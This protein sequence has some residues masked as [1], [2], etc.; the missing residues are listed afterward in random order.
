MSNN[1]ES[2]LPNAIRNVKLGFYIASVIIGF[3]GNTL[4]IAVISGKKNKRS[5]YDLFI[6]NLGIA[7][8]SFIV[9]Y[10]PLYIYE[11]LSSIYKTLLYC[12]LVQPLLTIFYFLSIFTIT[13]MAIHRCR[14]ITNPYKRKM[15][16]RAAYLWIATIW[17]SSF[18]IVLPLSIAA[19]VKDGIC[20]ENWP[21][22]NHRKAYTLALFLLQFLLP[23]LIIAVAYL[24]IGVYLWQSGDPQSS[25]PTAKKNRAQKRRK[26][27]IQVIKTLALIVILFAICLLPGQIA[28]L[29][30]DFGD[31]HDEHVVEVIFIFSDILD[32]LHAC[33]NPIVYGLLTEQFRRQYIIYVSYCL[34]CGTKQVNTEPETRNV[35]LSTVEILSPARNRKKPTSAGVETEANNWK[36]SPA[37]EAISTCRE[38]S[39]PWYSFSWQNYTLSYYSY[40]QTGILGNPEDPVRFCETQ[41]LTVIYLKITTH[42]MVVSFWISG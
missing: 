19:K 6:L 9:F 3:I 42:P 37:S 17:I 16:K 31:Q 11:H 20:L 36:G 27:N 30:W 24:R 8:L 34:S 21:S 41:I 38:S 33:V 10:M 26:E 4:V 39:S 23:L 18:I 2:E 40:A 14:L 5:V 7:D 15:R 1:T 32:C 35:E 28:W 13:S 25:L 29:M 22:M 12:R